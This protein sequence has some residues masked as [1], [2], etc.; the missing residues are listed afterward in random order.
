[1][2]TFMANK[3][4]V[5]LSSLRALVAE[6]GPELKREISYAQRMAIELSAERATHL[7][8]AD[9]LE[10]EIEHWL[11]RLERLRAA[12]SQINLFA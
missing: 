1:M 7:R 9:K 4:D 2:V 6:A 8:E 11:D 12:Q 3:L 5:Y 10:P